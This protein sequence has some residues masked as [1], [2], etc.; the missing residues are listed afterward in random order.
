[1][2]MPAGKAKGIIFRDQLLSSVYLVLAGVNE[3]PAGREVDGTPRLKSQTSAGL[4]T[5]QQGD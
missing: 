1:M 2:E 4:R 5:Q 3:H